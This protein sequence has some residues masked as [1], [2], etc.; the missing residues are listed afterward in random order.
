MRDCR[1]WV[2]MDTGRL[3]LLRET[4]SLSS[5][6]SRLASRAKAA[7]I[8]YGLSERSALFRLST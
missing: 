7:S 6:S 3:L 8:L 1:T 5:S 2:S 4:S